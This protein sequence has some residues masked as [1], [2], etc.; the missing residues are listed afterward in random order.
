MYISY[1][2][3]FAMTVCAA[4]SLFMLV[5]LF[6]SNYKLLGDNRLL[7]SRIKRIRKRCEQEHVSVPF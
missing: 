7:R 4:I 6:Y 1:Q 5:M 3:L 2:Q